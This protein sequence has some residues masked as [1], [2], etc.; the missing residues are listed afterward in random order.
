MTNVSII[1]TAKFAFCSWA[2]QRLQKWARTFF[3]RRQARC[4]LGRLSDRDLRDIGIT[5]HDLDLMLRTSL[6]SEGA[7]DRTLI[8]IRDERARNW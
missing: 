6:G 3:N 5:R 8:G 7:D 1:P 4:S 2:L